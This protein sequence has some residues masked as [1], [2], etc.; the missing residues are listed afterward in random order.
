MS[1]TYR[2]Y[3]DHDWIQLMCLA[4]DEWKETVQEIGK[5]LKIQKSEI[6]KAFVALDIDTLVG[7]IYGF[8]L[9]NGL[10]LP[11]YM[12]V[13]KD[14]R[15]QGVGEQLLKLLEKESGCNTSM[16]FYNISLHDHYSKLGYDSGQNL[17]TA[18]KELNPME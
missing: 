13:T 15:R 7:F 2:E 17:E 6:I 18:L 5:S 11:Q 8:T 12:Y 9:P 10:L 14:Y 1:I 16:V 3:N 4:E